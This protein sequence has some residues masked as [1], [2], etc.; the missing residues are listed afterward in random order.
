MLFEEIQ[1]KIANARELD[2]GTIFNQSIELFKKVWLQGLLTLIITFAM[3]IPFYIIMYLPMIAMGVIDPQSFEPGRDPNV[4]I[5]LP[6]FLFMIVFM[7]FA[8]FISFSMQAAF[9][10]ICRQKDLNLVGS[11][12]YFYF[13]KKRYIGKVLKLS[14]ASVGISLLAMLLC[15]FPLFYVMVPISFFS[16]MFA[17]NP[18][19]SGTNIIKASFALGNRKWLLA[20]GLVIISSIL[21]EIIGLLMCLVGLFVTASF[22]YLPLYFIYKEVVGFDESNELNQIGKSQEF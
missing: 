4:L 1:S 3:M 15:V 6:F 11:D 17:F 5:L 14:L 18:E 8:M 10:R 7:F 9:F 13:F 21:A 19:L 16:I 20:F 12:D 2:F 22:V